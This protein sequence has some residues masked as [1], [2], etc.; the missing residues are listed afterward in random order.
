MTGSTEILGRLG[1]AFGLEVAGIA[2]PDV[3]VA[4]IDVALLHMS[5]DEIVAVVVGGPGQATG[6]GW[7]GILSRLR[8]LPARAAVREPVLAE[9]AR[10]RVKRRA[11][12]LASLVAVGLPFDVAEAEV[13]LAFADPID[14]AEAL[15]ELHRLV[16]F[17][18][19]VLV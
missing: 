15:A 6:V 9:T 18:A 2:R 8:R 1:E 19:G 16:D 4:A 7:G 5:Q 12:L 3:F 13:R 17:V 11:A 10:E 14:A